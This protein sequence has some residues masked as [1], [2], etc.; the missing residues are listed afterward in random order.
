MMFEAKN[1]TFFYKKATSNPESAK[2]TGRHKKISNWIWSG[3]FVEK[4]WV[5]GFKHHY[6]NQI[7][8]AAPQ[9]QGPI[10]RGCTT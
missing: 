6:L 10:G 5:F 4:S 2:H 3:F 8:I 9:A 7:L 1:S